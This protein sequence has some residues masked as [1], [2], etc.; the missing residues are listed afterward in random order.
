VARQNV[1]SGVHETAFIDE[2]E[3]LSEATEVQLDAPDAG[4]VETQISLRVEAPTV[5]GCEKA[6]TGE[7]PP[8]HA[9]VHA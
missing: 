7:A 6:H 8:P 1:A 5:P 9:K 3:S 2:P 4:S